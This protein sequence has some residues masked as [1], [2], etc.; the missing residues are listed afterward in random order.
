VVQSTFLD[1]FSI[2]SGTDNVLAGNTTIANRGTRISLPAIKDSVVS[3]D[4]SSADRF[5]GITVGAASTGNLIAG[6][7]ANDNGSHGLLALPGTSANRFEHN[8]MHRNLIF[9]VNDLSWPSTWIGNDCETDSPAG[10][11]CGDG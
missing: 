4:T 1:R 8:S 11:I 3:A 10:M 6:N 2:P 9:D 7:E 5:D